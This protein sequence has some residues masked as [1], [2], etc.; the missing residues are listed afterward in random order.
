MGVSVRFIWCF[1]FLIFALQRRFVLG[2]VGGV[3]ALYLA[4]RYKLSS[5]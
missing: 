2:G 5:H 3:V 1:P 4:I